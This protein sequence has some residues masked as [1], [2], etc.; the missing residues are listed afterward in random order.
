MMRVETL[1]AEVQYVVDGEGQ[2]KAV[3]LD[4]QVWEDLIAMLTTYKE[5]VAQAIDDDE[6]GWDSLMKTI[7]DAVVDVGIEDLAHEHDHYLYGTPKRGDS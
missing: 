5:N 4:L 7:A 1:L 6:A 2:R 3:Q